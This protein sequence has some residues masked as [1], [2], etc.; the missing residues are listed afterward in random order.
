MEKEF[1]LT[2][3]RQVILGRLDGQQA[4]WSE[5]RLA[6]YGPERSKSK[7]STSF[8]IQLT[9]LMALN[10]VAKEGE[11]YKLTVEGEAIVAKAKETGVNF[12]AA[13]SLACLHYVPVIEPAPEAPAA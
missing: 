5:L 3:G 2:P 13:Q 6:Y 12:S 1:K 4:K 8:H 9:K 7:A 10:V 11:S